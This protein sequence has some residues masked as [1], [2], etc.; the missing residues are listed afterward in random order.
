VRAWLAGTANVL[1]AEHVAV[2]AAANKGD[3]EGARDGFATI[4][5]FV[6]DMES[7]SYNQKAKLGLKHR[8]FDCGPV[9]GPLLP[10]DDDVAARTLATL[11]AALG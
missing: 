2:L 8:G 10:L 9:R 11:A 5:P 1:P 4:L 7:G 6:Q 3:H